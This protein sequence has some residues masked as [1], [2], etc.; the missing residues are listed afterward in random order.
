MLDTRSPLISEFLKDHQRFSRLLLAITRLLEDG[1][2]DEARE[3]AREL[4]LVAG[5]HIEY[6]EREVYARLKQLG[7][8]RVTNEMLVG[9]HHQIRD[10]MKLLLENEALDESQLQQAKAGFASGIRHAEHCGSLISLMSRLDQDQ[11]AQ[12]LVVLKELRDGGRK[13]SEF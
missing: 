4:D 9:E 10:A 7:E 12:S 3:R 1:K 6:E 2:I 13:W 11:Q 8:T 5:P